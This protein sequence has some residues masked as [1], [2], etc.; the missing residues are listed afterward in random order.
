MGATESSISSR[1]DSYSVGAVRKSPEERK[2]SAG[3]AD[4]EEGNTSSDN[5]SS[6]LSSASTSDDEE[7]R[8]HHNRRSDLGWYKS[9]CKRVLRRANQKKKSNVDE[10]KSDSSAS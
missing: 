9:R 2:N 3:D 1:E 8:F 7:T 5:G 6:I 4:N 10:K